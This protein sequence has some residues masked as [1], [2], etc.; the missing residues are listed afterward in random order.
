MAPDLV[1]K[2]L[3]PFFS[4]DARW[5]FDGMACHLGWGGSAVVGGR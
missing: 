3:E 5:V 2:K 4:G 1:D